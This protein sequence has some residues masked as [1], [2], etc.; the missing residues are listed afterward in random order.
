MD[1]DNKNKFLLGLALV[2]FIAMVILVVLSF[3][4]I[5]KGKEPFAQD[6]S[7]GDKFLTSDINGNLSL[8]TTNKDSIIV[9]DSSGTMKNLPFPKG[10]IMI[11]HNNGTTNPTNNDLAPGWSLC[12]GGTYNGY[13]TPD[14]R[15][16]FVL[17]AGSGTGLTARTV[18]VVGG[19][20]THTLSVDEM[21]SHNH[22][23]NSN[24]KVLSPAAY[25]RD[26]D[27][28]RYNGVDNSGNALATLSAFDTS[29]KGGNQPH[30]NM[31]P[32]YVLCYICYTG[33]KL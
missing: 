3:K 27:N 10:L 22:N 30:N 4:K 29:L 23:L 16:R 6:P 14:L 1:T 24:Y 32:F 11:W 18:G 5:P 15:G 33:D 8:Y 28:G 2:F 12:D 20:E 25:S 19:T 26:L 7:S 17:G 31:P 21:P 13:K 9:T